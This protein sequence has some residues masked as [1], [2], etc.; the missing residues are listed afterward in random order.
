MRGESATNESRST[1]LKAARLRSTARSAAAV[2]VI[3]VVADKKC[4][5][6]ERFSR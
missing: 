2:A 5:N 6:I 3:A 1:G 4:D